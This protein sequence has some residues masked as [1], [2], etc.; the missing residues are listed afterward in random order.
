MTIRTAKFRLV[1]LSILGALSMAFMMWASMRL[2]MAVAAPDAVIVVSSTVDNAVAGDGHCTL[3]EA[4]NNANGDTDTT[5][6]DC[7]PGSGADAITL[8]AGTYTLLGPSGESDNAGGDLDVMTGTLTINGTGANVTIIR[9]GIGQPNV[10]NDGDRVFEVFFNASL[11][12]NDVTVRD[13]DVRDGAGILNTGT[14][15]LNRSG[16]ADNYTIE[17]GAGILNTGTL[18]VNQSTIWDNSTGT[19]SGT[20]GGLENFGVM[21]VTNSTISNNAADLYGAGI[22]NGGTAYLDS[23]T[24]F[25]NT[26]LNGGG[27]ANFGT[28]TVTNSILAGNHATAGPDCLGVMGS[29]GY[30]L[31]QTTT[32][33]TLAGTLT[34]VITGVNPLLG[35]LNEDNGT[36]PTH[37][38]LPG[39]PAVD[40]GNNG[41]CQSIDQRG[42][43]RPIDGDNDG[44]AV[45]DLGAVERSKRIYLPIILK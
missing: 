28:L 36:T 14:L 6:G 3:R 44:I 7:A 29:L 12:L 5:N 1:L 8:P 30:N 18:I 22:Y 38:L 37:D 13:G 15:I 17:D 16:V 32:G 35:P 40:A 9:N 2:Q 42:F 45:C 33:C 34:G 10:L 41:Q 4:I 39:S 23:V 43:K 27:L 26:A 25:S 19:P 31:I 20:A 11:T 21:T 24:V